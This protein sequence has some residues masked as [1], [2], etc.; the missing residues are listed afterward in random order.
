MDDAIGGHQIS[1]SDGD[2]VD[3]HGVVPLKHRP[4]LRQQPLLN[5]VLPVLSGGGGGTDHGQL[6]LV[7]LQGFDSSVG[8]H[9]PGDQQS[10]TQVVPE[11][12]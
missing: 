12:R 5:K 10:F 11:H 6:Q 2:L 7:S 4:R 3:I 8:A 1:I 9:S